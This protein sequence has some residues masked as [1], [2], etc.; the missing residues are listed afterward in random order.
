MKIR[1]ENITRFFSKIETS[2]GK[3][4]YHCHNTALLPSMNIHSGDSCVPEDFIEE[5]DKGAVY[6]QIALCCGPTWYPGHNS[7]SYFSLNSFL[8]AL[9]LVPSL[10]AVKYVLKIL[11]MEKIGKS[12]KRPFLERCWPSLYDS[13]TQDRLWTIITCIQVIDTV[14]HFFMAATSLGQIW[15]QPDSARDLHK[16]NSL[17]KIDH[18]RF[19]IYLSTLLYKPFVV[20]AFNLALGIIDSVEFI[21]TPLEDTEH[22]F[23]LFSYCLGNCAKYLGMLWV[24]LLGCVYILP[25]FFYSLILLIVGF[26]LYLGVYVLILAS[27]ISGMAPLATVSSDKSRDLVLAKTGCKCAFIAAICYV[28]VTLCLSRLYFGCGWK[29]TA[30]ALFKGIFEHA[31]FEMGIGWPYELPESAQTTLKISLA[32]KAISITL[33]GFLSSLCEKRDDKPSNSA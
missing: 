28:Y 16:V 6:Y 15:F 17:C 26:P 27:A 31:N 11:I 10:S 18:C 33:T 12:G 7:S 19:L 23:E 5:V 3:G 14:V 8:L 2:H 30:K 13:G 9:F 20:S 29:F 24:L 32:S 21:E 4:N 1:K 25:I 22:C